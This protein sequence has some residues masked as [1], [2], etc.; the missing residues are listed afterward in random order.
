MMKY[1][2]DGGFIAMSVGARLLVVLAMA[3]LAARYMGEYLKARE[4][5]VVAMQTRR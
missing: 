3:G 5:Q 1:K 4:W 2:H